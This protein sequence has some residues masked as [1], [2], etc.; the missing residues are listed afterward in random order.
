MI[1]YCLHSKL[2]A[3]MLRHQL[4]VAMLRVFLRV[5]EMLVQQSQCFFRMRLCL[6]IQVFATHPL[7]EPAVM[8]VGVSPHSPM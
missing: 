6:L 1:S 5:V 3:I 2:I 4:C 8:N 7:K